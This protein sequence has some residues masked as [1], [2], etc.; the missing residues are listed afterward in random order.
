MGKS[1]TT[2]EF[3]ARA[4]ELHVDLYDYSWVNYRNMNTNVTIF[5]RKHQKEFRQQPNNHLGGAG[6]PDCGIERRADVRRLTKEDFV[7]R[8]LKVHGD[9]YDY[10][11][12]VYRNHGTDVRIVCRTHEK[13]FL[14]TPNNHLAGSG[15]P[16]CGITRR[17]DSHRFTT[18]EF[19]ARAA[20]IHN[21]KYD[22]SSVAY[23]HSEDKVTIICPVHGPFSIVADWHVQGTGCAECAGVK[24]LTTDTFIFKAKKVHDDRY[25]YSKVSYANNWTKVTIVCPE[26]GPF[27]GRPVTHLRGNGCAKCAGVQQL[28]REEFIRRAQQAHGNA[29]DYTN[30]VY[31]NIMTDVLIFCR[32]HE[33]PFA[34]RPVHHM[35]GI[36]CPACGQDKL[37]ELFKDTL[38]TFIDKARNIHGDRYDYSPVKYVDSATKI[39]I[40]CSKHGTFWQKPN[41]HIRGSGCA[42]CTTNISKS[43]TKWLD[44]LGVPDRQMR[45]RLPDGRGFSA[46][47]YDPAT[48]TVYRFHGDYWHGNPDRFLPT[49]INKRINVTF[50]VLYEATLATDQAI[51]DAGFNLFVIWE[52]EWEQMHTRR[53]YQKGRQTYG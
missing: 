31:K 37:S 50:G 12:V 38:G 8:A 4:T 6:C 28:T 1:L 35:R 25:D 11:Q 26:H 29:Y 15:C 16:Y 39:Q 48:N 21:G 13:E 30:V 45:F 44:S 52:S 27:D 33:Q 36:G 3:V 7:S 42:F 43:E 20:K 32:K 5:C 34:Q 40:I 2:V 17:A 47:G 22:Y 53:S 41:S 18:E 24:R 51:R 14:Q 10:S 23:T 9:K 46:D 49:K 19:I